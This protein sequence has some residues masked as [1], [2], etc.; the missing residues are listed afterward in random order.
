MSFSKTL[1]PLRRLDEVEVQVGDSEWIITL[2]K[3]SAHNQEFRSRVAEFT[4]RSKNSKKRQISI[5]GSP[6]SLTGTNDIRRDA[7]FFYE[8]F[9]V[10]WRGLK[11]DAGKD[12]PPSKEVAAEIFATKEGQVLVELLL[13]ESTKDANFQI[14]EGEDKV[15]AG[16]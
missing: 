14:K 2:R 8:V 4:G 10:T 11:D 5:G 12:T 6:T 3:A 13:N 7:E 15:I 1:K 9:V 16:E